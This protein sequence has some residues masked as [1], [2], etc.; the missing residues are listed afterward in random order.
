MKTSL[1]NRAKDCAISVPIG[2]V[3]MTPNRFGNFVTDQQ[4]LL[5]VVT[6]FCFS[7][8]VPGPAAAAPAQVG[9]DRR[10]S[11]VV[12]GA[13][14]A[15]PDGPVGLQ[16]AAA[17][18]AALSAAKSPS[19]PLLATTSSQQ[20]AKEEQFPGANG[21]SR[22]G[23]SRY[24]C[25]FCGKIFP[26]S[27]NLTRHLRTHTGE[28]PYKCKYCERSFSISSNLQRHVRNIHNR[29]KPF[30]VKGKKGIIGFPY[31]FSDGSS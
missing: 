30:K 11:V 18:E 1:P 12:V 22:E 15:S 6:H 2:P 31:I 16:Q 24:S 5:F 3:P 13:S 28:Q 8:Q 10:R 27:A 25:K 9:H 19:S 29:E 4:Q 7:G 14:P 23:K 17:E 26:R 20:G 21:S